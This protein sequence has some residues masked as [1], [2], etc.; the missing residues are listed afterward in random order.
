MTTKFYHAHP[1][2]DNCVVPPDGYYACPYPSQASANA[3]RDRFPATA[4]AFA[5]NLLSELSTDE[6]LRGADKPARDAL[7]QAY[8]ALTGTDLVY[9]PT[10]LTQHGREVIGATS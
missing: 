2:P 8:A 5:V 1:D 10:Q 4:V 3:A 7:V 6:W 9:S